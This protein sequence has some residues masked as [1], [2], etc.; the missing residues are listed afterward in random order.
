[1]Q[2]IIHDILTT[3]ITY[4]KIFS[5]IILILYCINR[6]LSA[7]QKILQTASVSLI[8][9]LFSLLTLI[10]LFIGNYQNFLVY[11]P[12]LSKLHVFSPYILHRLPLIGPSI[13]V[14]SLLALFI[15]IPGIRRK[16]FRVFPL[17]TANPLHAITLSLTMLVLIRFLTNVTIGPNHL[18]SNHHSSEEAIIVSAWIQGLFLTLIGVVG[19]GWLSRRTLKSSF[20]RL[21]IIKVP[22]TQIIQGVITGSALAFFVL[23]IEGI[24]SHYGLLD[25]QISKSTN[26]I[27]GP[28]FNSSFGILTLGFAAAIGEETIFRGALLPRFGVIYSS[29]LFALVHVHY[30]LSF[31]LVTIFFLGVF[32]SKLRQRYNTT[33]SIIVHATYNM[34]LGTIAYIAI[35]FAT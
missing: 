12:T 3:I 2:N 7:E 18:T 35:K 1:M 34:T 32:L 17:S 31:Q 30:G 22:P 4:F 15:L 13:W 9:I 14:P 33:I 11:F 26:E 5:P 28:L 19:V 21:G 23:F 29:L 25:P 6:S 16:L 20:E 8:T 24:V 10:G 27:I